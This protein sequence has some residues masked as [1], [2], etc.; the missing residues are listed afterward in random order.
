M[1]LATSTL[2]TIRQKV[3]RL[4]RSPSEQ[5]LSDYELDQYINTSI[6]FDF[7]EHLRL[8]S[9]ATN[10]TFYTQAGVDTY[11]TSTDPNNALYDF[12]DLYINVHPEA[13]I[14]GIPAGYTQH[15]DVFYGQWPQTVFVTN[16]LIQGNGSEGPFSGIV[17]SFPQNPVPTGP[18]TGAILQNSF[19][20]TVLDVNH[21]SMVLVDYPSTIDPTIGYLGLVNS[22]PVPTTPIPYGTINYQTGVFTCTFPNA[23]LNKFGNTIF[24]EAELYIPGLPI[25]VL[26]YDNQFILRPVPNMAYPV[27]L[28]ADIR[29]TQLLATTDMPQIT[30]W[31]QFIA[32]MTAK[33]VL[34]DRMDLDTV[35]MIMPEYRNQMNFV[36]RTNIVQRANERT[37]T[38]YTEGKSY[39]WGWY[40]NN[41]FPF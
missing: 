18:Y 33:K 36:N 23:T 30:Q 25:S 21:I 22:K 32:Y 4:T 2:D 1:A 24:A 26:F 3:R 34:E 38:I 19:I 14:A 11:G 27:Q 39:G 15:K 12:K 28:K 5:Q 8:F 31:W 37:V 17:N 7:P 10:L 13:Y 6:A 35:Q 29:P 16:T 20:L 41:N 40:G 9:L